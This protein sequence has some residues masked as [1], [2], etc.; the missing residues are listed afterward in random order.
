MENFEVF[1]DMM[2]VQ[3]EVE[4][5]A[6]DIPEA[7]PTPAGAFL[8]PALALNHSLSSV[9]VADPALSAAALDCLTAAKAPGTV[10]SYST[11]VKHFK[12]FCLLAGYSFPHFTTEAITQFVL[13]H[14]V[15][16]TGY[17]FL[18]C[19][20]PALVYLEV[21][22]GK[23]TSFTPTIDLLLKGAKRRARARSGPAKKAPALSP[24]QLAS[25]LAKIYPPEDHV[26]LA[27]PIRLRTAFRALFIYHTLC[28]Y[29]CFAKLQAKHFEPTG[30]D[31][32][33]TFPSSKND[34]M[35]RGQQSCLAATN[36][37]LC[38]VRITKLYFRRF[39]LRMGAEQND[40]SFVSFRLRRQSARLLPIKTSVL[41]SSQAT[42]D[43]RNLLAFCGHSVP[44]ATDK[45]PKMTGVTAALEAGA[46][47]LEVSQQ[48]R[49]HT[50]DVVLRYKENSLAYKRA[51]ALKV[52]SLQPP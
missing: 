36:S 15:R 52:P 29:S 49:W 41:S 10:K 37:P 48:G 44:K 25:V 35:H 19:I 20:K 18:S 2:D 34:Q 4:V 47:P 9:L 8:S 11:V 50:Q 1:I 28:R 13:H 43:W 23:T 32:M 3:H 5:A 51:V 39:G 40:E 6:P 21:A 31:I 16:H 38:P 14:A 33:V 22:M 12:A 26:G 7:V 46:T 30:D 42:Q 24:V 17:T 27:C 45:T